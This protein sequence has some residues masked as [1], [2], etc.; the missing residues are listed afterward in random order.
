M[1][2]KDK[3]KKVKKKRIRHR[4]SGVVAWTIIGYLCVAVCALYAAY[5]IHT[6][7]EGVIE[8]Y[9]NQ[10]DAYVQLVLDQINLRKEEKTPDDILEIIGTLDSSKNKYWTLS[11]EQT[12]LFVK[13]VTETNKYKGFTTGTYYISDS[14]QRFV[15][16][17][18]TNRVEHNLIEIGEKNYIT[19][20]V[21]F[22]YGESDY[23]ICLLTNPEAVLDQ[24]AYL[25]AKVNLSLMIA[26]VLS[27]FLL[28]ILTMARFAAKRTK[29]LEVEQENNRK[30]YQ[31]IENLNEQMATGEMY[32]V[33]LSLFQKEYFHM[34]YSKLQD[35]KLKPV[36]LMLLRYKDEEAKQFFLQDSILMMEKRIL[37]FKDDANQ[38]ILL[39]G[40]HMDMEATKKTIEWILYKKLQIIA[41]EEIR[42][43]TSKDSKVVLEELYSKV[44]K[45]D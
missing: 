20:G 19:S 26:V 43:V 29:E 21:T 3:N 15:D 10:Q 8:I 7:E 24:N 33:R 4:G 32:D 42:D 13:D 40:L 23:Q 30:L 39:V 17:L 5:Q 18:A 25:G 2:K 11:H 22:Q 12:I 37:R 1:S 6:Y 34:L 16:G 31:M 38:C 14:A 35:R 44:E 36:T 9:A 28:I 45:H 27:A 41:V